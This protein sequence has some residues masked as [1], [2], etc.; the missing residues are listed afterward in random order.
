MHSRLYPKAGVQAA[1]ALFSASILEQRLRRAPFL[2]LGPLTLGALVSVSS[3]GV[4]GGESGG[5]CP[6]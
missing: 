4:G 2:C 1:V 6:G 5:H 3:G